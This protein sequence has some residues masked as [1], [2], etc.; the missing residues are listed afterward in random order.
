M[1]DFIL[2]VGKDIKWLFLKNHCEL[3]KKKTD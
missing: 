1:R 3:K 2:Q